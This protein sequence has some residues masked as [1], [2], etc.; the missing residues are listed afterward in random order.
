MDK[1][2]QEI[3]EDIRQKLT[4]VKSKLINSVGLDLMFKNLSISKKLI[5][6]FSC[7][8]LIPLILTILVS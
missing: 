1:Q 3:N 7:F 5:V 8:G 6:L 2:L 4:D